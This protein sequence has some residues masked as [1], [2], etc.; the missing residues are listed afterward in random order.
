MVKK[1][2][3]CLRKI[4]SPF[5]IYEDF[6]NSSKY[7]IYGNIYVDGDVKVRDHCHVTG[8]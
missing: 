2:L 5:I 6:E 8:K 4:E 3:G 1:G 7:W